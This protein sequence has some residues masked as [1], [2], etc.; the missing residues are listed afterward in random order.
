MSYETRNNVD[1]R[2]LRTYRYGSRVYGC[3]TEKSDH[4]FI[5]IVESN[6][7]LY[8][9]VNFT[10][11]NI[12]V[13]SESMFIQRILDHH[14]SALESIFLYREDPFLKYFNLDKEILR[15]SISAVTSNS[16]V[17][18][19]KKL[20]QGDYYIGKKSL[21]HSLR[22]LNFGIQIA[23]YGRIQDYS[24]ANVFHKMIMEMPSNDWEDYKNRFQPIY[25]AQKT[26]FKKVAPLNKDIEQ[27][28]GLK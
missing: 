14:I 23:K 6:K 5:V 13:Y 9:N 25:N 3:H 8:Y 7:D 24:S 1:E 22:I 21:F 18:C 11:T 19:K 27:L 20:A 12:T 28:R 10:N 26:L 15:H 4:D 2:I 17:K 16:F